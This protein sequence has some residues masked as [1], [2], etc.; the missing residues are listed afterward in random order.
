[1][2]TKIICT[3][4]PASWSPERIEQLARTGMNVARV[5]C[6]HGTTE[7]NRD[8]I[9]RLK[10]VRTKKKLDFQIMLDTKG[11]DIRI[12]ALKGGE[13][14]LVTGQ[15]LMLSNYECVGNCACVSV[16]YPTNFAQ[17]MKVGQEILVDDARLKLV[18]TD[19][20]GTNVITRVV[21]GGKLGQRKSLYI[22][23]VDF[24]M[25]FL[26]ELD[27]ADLKMGTEET[28]DMVAASFVSHAR[29]VVEMREFIGKNTPI[30]SKIESS[31]SI[32]NLDEIIAI[33]DGIM[34]ARGD[35]G[36]AY[37]LEQIP[38]LQKHI[39]RKCN[40]AGRF[41]IVATEMLESMTY[42]P[43]P[44]RAEVGDVANAVWDG[45]TAVMTSG[46]TARG[47]WPIECVDIMR[48]VVIEAEGAGF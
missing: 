47:E 35:L 1:M 11:P 37:P 45:A 39:I 5:N 15:E 12:G 38:T 9:R 17:S 31:L 28:V 8:L 34:V 43:R 42:K 19:V 2:K 22:P 32:K 27:K 16:P 23:D 26:S 7:Q 24:K 46:E 4:G 41:V 48:R 18:V 40:A 20:K 21:I 10:D 44:T 25:P 36:V 29:E 14:E 30:I 3:I 33:S 6:S 13:V